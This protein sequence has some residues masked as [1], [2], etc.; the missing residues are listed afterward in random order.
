MTTFQILAFLTVSLIIFLTQHE[1]VSA[2]INNH[3][4]EESSKE[5]N[6]E[7]NEITNNK[8]YVPEIVLFTNIIHP[9][10]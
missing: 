2:K 1:K 3:S 9:N 5:Q 8:R 7:W 4:E 6:N 10:F